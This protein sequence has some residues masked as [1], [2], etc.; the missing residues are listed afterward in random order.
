[1]RLS[2]GLAFVYAFAA[3]AAPLAVNMRRDDAVANV[4]AAEA[5]SK[6]EKVDTSNSCSLKAPIPVGTINSKRC[7]F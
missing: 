2:I 3:M 6:E 4:E 7:I 5:I 1:M